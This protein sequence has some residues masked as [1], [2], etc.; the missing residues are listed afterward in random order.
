MI[1]GEG[2]MHVQATKLGETRLDAYAGM[3]SM[4]N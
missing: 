1:G 2:I 4:L 3:A